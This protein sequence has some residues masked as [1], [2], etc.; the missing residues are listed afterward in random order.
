MSGLLRI[1]TAGSVDDGKSTLI[2]R[3]LFDSQAI[4]A[5]QLDTLERRAAGRPIDLSLLTDGLEAERE[6]GITIDVAYR[7][8][9]TKKRAFIVADTPGHE[10]YTRNMVVATSQADVAI[11]LVDASRK[12]TKQTRRHLYLCSLLRVQ[13]VIF[14][15]NKFAVT[16]D[17]AAVFKTTMLFVVILL[18]DININYLLPISSQQ[19]FIKNP[20]YL[21]Y[22]MVGVGLAWASI[23][24]M[25]YVILSG[26][27]P[28]KKM[29]IYMGIFNFF[30]TLPQI[31]NGIFGGM[32]V[33][34][35]YH[36]QPIYAIV[37]AGV[38]L[39]CAAISVLFV[40]EK[41]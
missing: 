38:L 22:S 2:G 15:I 28:A 20:D 6:Q 10:Q 17:N 13:T 1:C 5:D 3:L 40:N 41:A 34:H 23:L 4:L 35:I 31:V 16:F 27:I 39:I 36:G 7:Y 9:S 33:K 37:L 19:Y 26:S 14:A 24:A 29:G 32:I 8:F 25:P 21:T 12:L 11:L 30:I 18:D